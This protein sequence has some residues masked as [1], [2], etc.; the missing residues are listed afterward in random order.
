MC[1]IYLRCKTFR[2]LVLL[3]SSGDW[4]SLYWHFFVEKLSGSIPYVVTN[5]TDKTCQ[6][7]NNN[8]NHLG[9]GVQPSSETSGVSNRTI[10]HTIE[11]SNSFSIISNPHCHKPFRIGAD[12]PTDEYRPA[13]EH[14][15]S[16]ETCLMVL[17]A[18][19]SHTFEIRRQS[20]VA[21]LLHGI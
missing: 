15:W 3:P 2:E 5:N 8:N 4:F 19:Q 1:E 10:P 13:I 6:Y 7:N 18:P 14:D 9:T 12:R 16:R 17:H 11:M 20:L 21:E